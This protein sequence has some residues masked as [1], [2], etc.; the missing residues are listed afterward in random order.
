MVAVTALAFI[1]AGGL[2]VYD[3]YQHNPWLFHKSHGKS[4]G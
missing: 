1:V 4:R 2:V 3:V